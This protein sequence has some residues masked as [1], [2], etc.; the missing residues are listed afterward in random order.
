MWLIS[1]II[2]VW[3]AGWY[4][5]IFCDPAC[6]LS[7]GLF[8]EYWRRVYILYLTLGH[9]WL[10]MSLLVPSFYYFLSGY[11]CLL[12]F[13]FSGLIDC[14]G[15]RSMSKSP[16]P[17]LLLSVLSFM[18]LGCYFQDCDVHS[19]RI[20]AA[21]L[22]PWPEVVYFWPNVN[23]SSCS[24]VLLLVTHVAQWHHISCMS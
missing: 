22:H 5:L 13:C 12:I 7:W 15:D 24:L 17:V 14:I 20:C 1:I 19:P 9:E 23:T 11:C 8:H 4:D 21:S 10:Y 2:V 16:T 18:S 3:E 6:G